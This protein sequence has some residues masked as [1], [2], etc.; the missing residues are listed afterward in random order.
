[1]SKSYIRMQEPQEIISIESIH[2]HKVQNKIGKWF[3][4]VKE[5]VWPFWS[6]SQIQVTN[7]II[8][9]SRS[10]MRF[11]IS[12]LLLT[13]LGHLATTQKVGAACSADEEGKYRCA[14]N[15]LDI[16]ICHLDQWL[17]S[18]TCRKN[19]C[20]DVGTPVCTC[21]ANFQR[22]VSG[23]LLLVQQARKFSLN[24]AN[25]LSRTVFYFNSSYFKS[26]EWLKIVIDREIGVGIIH[27][28]QHETEERLVFDSMKTTRSAIGYNL[29]IEL[30]RVSHIFRM[31]PTVINLQPH[32]PHGL[33][34][35]RNPG[36]QRANLIRVA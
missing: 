9:I 27:L 23:P 32:W 4:Q 8:Q 20:R 30:R 36:W 17:L 7:T 25:K 12:L 29:H 21:Q 26:S 28:V 16:L 14:N 10:T 24:I 33:L 2:I 15:N 3:Y 5:G 35:P 13:H 1:M 11:C 6:F 31:R 34:N 18:A 22:S 19:C